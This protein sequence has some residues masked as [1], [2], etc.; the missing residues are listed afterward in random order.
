M[1][2]SVK[3]KLD[4][5]NETMIDRRLTSQGL[6]DIPVKKASFADVLIEEAEN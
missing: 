4:D 3:L 2:C 6:L 1:R 5:V